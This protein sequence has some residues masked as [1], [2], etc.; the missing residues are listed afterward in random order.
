MYRIEDLIALLQK[1]EE[2]KAE[3][4]KVEIVHKGQVRKE[5]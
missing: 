2:E 4:D 3:E 5:N 1:K